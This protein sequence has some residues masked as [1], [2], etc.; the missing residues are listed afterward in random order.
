MGLW[1][2]VGMGYI[3]T[4]RPAIYETWLFFP[5]IEMVRWNFRCFGPGSCSSKRVTWARDLLE[6]EAEQFIMHSVIDPDP[7][8]PWLAQRMALRIPYSA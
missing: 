8:R 3:L 7:E 5:H 1:F 4:S 6:E 2:S